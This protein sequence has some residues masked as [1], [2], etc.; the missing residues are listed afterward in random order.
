[1]TTPG[2]DFYFD[3]LSPYAY[4]AWRQIQPLCQHYA[5][6]LRPHPVVFGKLLDHWG[7]LG[8][9]EIA[10]KKNALYKY[11]Y[12]YAQLHGFKFDPP[13]FH[14]Y[15]PLP[16]LRLSL[17]QVC[18]ERQSELIDTLFYAGWSEGAD[19]GSTTELASTLNNAGFEATAL[20]AA[21]E[22][23]EVK[24]ILHRETELAIGKGVFG[25]PTFIIGGELFWG[26]DQLEHIELFLQ[27][28]DPLKPE[29][30]DEML[31]RHRGIDRVKTAKSAPVQ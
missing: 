16:S 27:G 8:P 2:M 10:P 11:C 28:K 4:F 3:Y 15:N 21:I 25:V 19:L 7:Q 9:A 17:P 12:R 23:Q 22:T 20:L 13:R 31:A 14:P 29:C 18:G 1:M 5:V 30:V 6:D 24:D 26:N